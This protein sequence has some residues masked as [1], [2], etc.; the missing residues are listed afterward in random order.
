[1]ISVGLWMWKYD[2]RLVTALACY[3]TI[4]IPSHG[5]TANPQPGKSDLG[6][7]RLDIQGQMVIRGNGAY[8]YAFSHGD[9]RLVHER[10]VKLVLV[11]DT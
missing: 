5:S 2:F 10:D 9:D 4:V 11:A 8:G 6:S 1:V 3:S 7:A